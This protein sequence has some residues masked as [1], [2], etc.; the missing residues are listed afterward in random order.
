LNDHPSREEVMAVYRGGLSPERKE[1]VLRHLL[2]PCERCLDEAAPAMGLALGPE[3]PGREAVAEKKTSC[4]AAINRA[5]RKVLRY[6]RYLRQQRAQALEAL[7]VLETGGMAALDKLPPRLGHFARMEA[8]LVRSWQLRHDN[9]QLMVHFAVL[10]TEVSRRLDARRFDCPA[11]V[12]DF[13]ARAQAELGNAYRA[14]QR[15]HEAADALGQ[16]RRLFERGTRDEI[17]EVRLLE[18]EASLAADRREFG[19]ASASLVKVA[20]FYSRQNDPHRVGRTLVKLGLYAGNKGDLERAVELLE[21]SL[22]LIDSKREP[23][24]ACAA[25]HNL[26]VFLIDGGRFRD[27]KKLRLAHARHLVNPGGRIN[28]IKFRALEGRID[29]GLGNYPRAETIFAEVIAGF[30]EVGLPI[31]ASIERLDLAAAL[32]AQGKAGEA[33]D[34]I[35]EAAEIFA[36]L[37][38]QREALMAVVLL[39]DAVEMETATLEMVE[40]VARFLRRIEIDPALRF[41]GRAWEE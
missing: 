31:V 19:R 38:I 39:R 37:E 25:A 9:P 41:E 27:A 8:F 4:D 29:A 15:L 32:L 24:L 13:Q 34:L 14:A 10:A 20:D 3:P 16:A 12:I 7:R 5:L 26:L 28:E 36:R 1:E 18:L 6:E 30:E 11:R 21:K 40:E 35:L 2:A 17:L 33:F 23:S 22:D